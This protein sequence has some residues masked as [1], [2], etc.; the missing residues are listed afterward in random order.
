M[1]AEHLVQQ[2]GVVQAVG[3]ALKVS[4]LLRGAGE[5]QGDD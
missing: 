2:G 3:H 5:P 1:F 4:A